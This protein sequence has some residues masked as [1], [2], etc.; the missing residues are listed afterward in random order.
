M[1]GNF[2]FNLSD[3]RDLPD[4]ALSGDECPEP[5]LVARLL[6]GSQN[7]DG[8]CGIM[9]DDD[10]AGEPDPCQLRPTE[11]LRTRVVE[12]MLAEAGCKEGTPWP[13]EERR[14]NCPR[15]VWKEESDEAGLLRVGMAGVVAAVV[16]VVF[17]LF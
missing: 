9:G 15:E 7:R 1:H 2:S 8:E 4:A 10:E 16:A 6:K 3:D 5:L 13:D 17:L 14:G 11:E 12:A